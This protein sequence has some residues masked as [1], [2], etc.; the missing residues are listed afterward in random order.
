MIF[1]PATW[2]LF[3]YLVMIVNRQGELAHSSQILRSIKRCTID[4][5]RKPSKRKEFLKTCWLCCCPNQWYFTITGHPELGFQVLGCNG[6]GFYCAAIPIV[7][8]TTLSCYWIHT[9][10]KPLKMA[11]WTFAKKWFLTVQSRRTLPCRAGIQRSSC[12]NHDENDRA[13]MAIHG[14]P[15]LMI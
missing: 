1:H 2:I 6:I 7:R 14:Y 11:T 5:R 10:Q 4:H 3:L 8:M 9:I 15:T 12:S 13:H